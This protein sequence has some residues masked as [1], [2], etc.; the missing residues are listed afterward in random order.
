[1]GRNP[2][3]GIHAA[4]ANSVAV[5]CLVYAGVLALGLFTLPSPAQPIQNPWFSA[6]EM[7]I[8][9]IAPAMVAL[10]AVVHERASIERK[11]FGVAAVAFMS[12][13]AVI[14]CCVHFS[15]LT[16]SR[17]PAFVALPW[18][19]RVFSFRWPSMAYALD[20]LAWDIF[21]P[22]AALCA[23]AAI[24]GSGLLRAARWLM[25]AS[26]GFSFAGLLG[27]P[28]GDMNVRNIGIVGYVG[29]CPL[30]AAVLAKAYGRAGMPV[31]Q[32]SSND[33]G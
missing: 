18:A 17:E 3:H 12:M 19:E 32:R 21:F 33:S 8:L 24:E 28:L 9:A 4:I 16:L 7:L 27:I 20:V 13:C 14:T 26:A 31:V 5:L 30:A 10:T 1:M 2:G 25:Y 23:A 15:I 11:A 22:L 29:A 6:L